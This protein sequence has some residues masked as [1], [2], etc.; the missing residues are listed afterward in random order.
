MLELKDCTFEYSTKKIFEGL[1]INFKANAIY[2]VLGRNGIG[3]TTLF[4]IL[5]NVLKV[6]KGQIQL[7]GV[8]LN[9]KDVSILQTAP[10]FYPY[11]KGRVIICCSHISES[12]TDSSDTIH[13]IQEGYQYELHEKNN[14]ESLHLAIGKI[15]DS[16]IE[17][18]GAK[19]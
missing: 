1:T 9:P 7:H 14:Y 4:K 18:L 19:S 2:G 13:F 11:M 5:T 12:L 8:P 10:F 3:K 6:G 15:I 17:S 16:K